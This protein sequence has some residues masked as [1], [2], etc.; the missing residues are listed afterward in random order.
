MMKYVCG[1][2][3]CMSGIS[4]CITHILGEEANSFNSILSVQ[5]GKLRRISR[6]EK[7]EGEAALHKEL[8]EKCIT[9]K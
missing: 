4:V 1:Q 6:A 9:Y 7:R 2:S 3:L 5:Q 8:K